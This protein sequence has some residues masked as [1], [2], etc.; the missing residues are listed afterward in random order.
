MSGAHPSTRRG[1]WTDGPRQINPLWPTVPGNRRSDGGDAESVSVRD[2]R[3]SFFSENLRIWRMRECGFGI[4]ARRR[5]EPAATGGCNLW[6]RSDGTLRE[7]RVDIPAGSVWRQVRLGTEAIYEV[8][9][10][11]GEHADVVVRTAPGAEARRASAA[12]GERD[13]GN[14]SARRRPVRQPGMRFRS[15]FHLETLETRQ[16]VAA[17][18]DDVRV[19]RRRPGPMANMPA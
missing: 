10:I 13:R 15:E 5:C 17:G 11:D 9:A 4:P 12:H 19:E 3:R 6:P 16:R 14:G 1:E 7:R 8:V 18:T 2:Q